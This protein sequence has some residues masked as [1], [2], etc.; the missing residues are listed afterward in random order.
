MWK[1]SLLPHNFF[2]LVPHFTWQAS[3][4][5][6]VISCF[7]THTWFSY[8]LGILFWFFLWPCLFCCGCTECSRDKKLWTVKA[9][10]KESCCRCQVVLP[11]YIFS[12]FFLRETGKQNW[13]IPPENG[14]LLRYRWHYDGI[15]GLSFPAYSNM[16]LHYHNCN[17]LFQGN[18]AMLSVRECTIHFIDYFV[19]LV[20]IFELSRL[21]FWWT[22]CGWVI[23]RKVLPRDNWRHWVISFLMGS[24]WDKKSHTQLS[25][26]SCIKVHQLDVVLVPLATHGRNWIAIRHPSVFSIR[27]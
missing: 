15:G 1:Y 2:F 20:L 6:W 22:H 14:S 3:N 13:R 27:M 7:W 18:F 16:I 23:C 25:I 5:C 11:L 4:L 8:L 19:P 24:Y 12:G 9:R 21:F 17:A 10:F 26:I